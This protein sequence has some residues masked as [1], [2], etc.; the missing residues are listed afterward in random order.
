MLISTHPTFLLINNCKTSKQLQQVHAQATTR[1]L[2][3]LYPSLIL[4]KILYTFSLL[5]HLTTTSPHYPLR[6]FNQI[7]NPSTFCYNTI[8]RVY[9]LLSSPLSALSLFAKMRRLCIPPDTHTF[10]FVLKA[11]VRLR[12]LALAKTLHSQ[13]VKFGFGS[14]LFV[15]N[16]LIHVYSDLGSMTDAC[17]LF[18]VTPQRDVVSYN[19]I[20][21]GFVKAGNT[22]RARDIFDEMLVRD[23]VTWG[24]LLAGYAQM[25]QCKEAIQL[26]NQMLAS[27]LKPNNIALVS[28]LSA[29][30]QL[31]ALDQGKIIHNHIEQNQIRLDAFLATGL[32][33]MYAKC[34]CIDLAREVF[35][36][37]EEKKLFTW[38]AM[39]VGLAMHGDGEL[40]LE[41]FRRMKEAGIKPDGVS[42]LGVL[43]GCSHAGLVNEAQQLFND[44]ECVYGLP[45][46]LKHYGCMADLLGRAGL[47]KEAI[48]MIQG[49]PMEG[50]VFV[51]GGL[52]GGCSI[53]GNVEVAEIAAKHIMQLDPE[54]G[55]VYSIMASIYAHARRWEDVAKIRR[56][57]DA[58]RVNKS[59]GCS[60]IQ[61]GGVTHEFV[62]GERLH[63]QIDEIYWVLDGIQRQVFES[64]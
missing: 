37:S 64:Y 2:M 31:G 21:H 36:S 29:C 30:A 43:V 4:T 11:S 16:S 42:F 60:S 23:D 12:A 24:T 27:G 33:D 59:A 48:R 15:L 40:S 32:V 26:F 49:M 9:T 41:Y 7:P 63:P 28:A 47:I 8:I 50:D 3:S 35:E 19:S 14:D 45:R 51:W 44:M 54:D 52:L 1:G 22:S 57:M 62:A 46:E 39:I 58:R 5:D 55:G 53:H 13:V 20:I 10:P 17:Q 18:D 61:L 38:N 6:I 25:N 56:L 34:G